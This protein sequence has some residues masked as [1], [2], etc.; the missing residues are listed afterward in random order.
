MGRNLNQLRE[1]KDG[2]L[3]PAAH[4]HSRGEQGVHMLSLYFSL[5]PLTIQKIGFCF[6]LFV[7]LSVFFSFSLCADGWLPMEVREDI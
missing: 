2:R 5:S 3:L 6:Y 1:E 4:P 7:S